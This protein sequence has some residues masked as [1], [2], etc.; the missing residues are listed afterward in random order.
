MKNN[1]LGIIIFVRLGSKRL[2]NKAFTKIKNIYSL[3]HVYRRVKRVDSKLKIIEATTKT[4]LDN[5]IVNY[6]KLKKIK[7]FRGSNKN[8]VL[9]AIKCC[10]NYN[11]NS[12]LR[13]CADR[14]F[15]DFILARKMIEFYKKNNFEIVTNCLSKTYPEGLG[16]EIVNLHILKKNHKYMNSSD[17]EHILNYFYRN[18]KKFKIKN[19]RCNFPKNVSNIS[20]A[21]D[22]ESDLY[23]INKAYNELKISSKTKSKK[24]INYFLNN[25]Y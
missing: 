18:N 6:C 15:F 21:L 25:F 4:K 23:K 10:E 19:F 5:K 16:C 17:K 12:F 20:M 2:P 22:N 11:F 1:K 9:R 7:F 3:E 14:I 13:V 24:I 8:V